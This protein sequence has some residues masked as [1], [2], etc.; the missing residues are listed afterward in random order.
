MTRFY[1]SWV[2]WEWGGWGGSWYDLPDNTPGSPQLQTYNVIS[3]FIRL[4]LHHL[5][6]SPQLEPKSEKNVNPET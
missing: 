1:Y 4:N 3:T 2:G 6:D 5:T